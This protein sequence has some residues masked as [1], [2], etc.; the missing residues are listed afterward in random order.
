M[1]EATQVY[2]LHKFIHVHVLYHAMAVMVKLLCLCI[3]NYEARFILLHRECCCAVSSSTSY[4][5]CSSRFYTKFPAL[6]NAHLVSYLKSKESMQKLHIYTTYLC[7]K[8]W[9]ESSHVGTNAPH[10]LVA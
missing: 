6:P 5:L 1:L 8:P 10:E 2:A 4:V 7:R 3:V 9:H